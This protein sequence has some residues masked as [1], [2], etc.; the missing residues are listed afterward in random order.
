M[1]DPTIPHFNPGGVKDRVDT[2]DFKWAEIGF[3][4]A[5]FDWDEG[6]DIEAKLGINLPVKDQFGSFSCGGQAW[7]QYAGVLEASATGTLEERSAKFFYA[8]TYQFG[9]GS[10]GRDNADIFINQGS[11][12]ELVLPSY[13]PGGSTTEAFITRGQDITDLARTD[14][15]TAQG[16]SYAQTGTSIDAIA[17]AIRD[18]RGAVLGLDGQNNGTW[19]SAFPKPPTQTE[20]RHWVF[21][22][23]PK[24]INGVK[25]IGFLNSWGDQ[26]GEGGWQWI[27]EQ[28]FTLGHVWSGWTHILAPILP[29]SFHH[30]FVSDLKFEQTGGD[31]IALQKALQLDGSFPATVP[32]TGFYGD[33][34]R[35]AVLAFQLKYMIAPLAE[36]HALQGKTVG[37]KTRAKLNTLFN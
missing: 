15:H 17:Q 26:I 21:A 1:T 34:T 37:P 22:G 13:L 33:I 27:P 9:G 4:S 30:N 6:Y 2:R 24:K 31:I 25:H 12:R 14:A 32:T 28:Y 35:R 10:T 19:A 11:C 20:W 23:K 8:Q 16:F 36:L 5:P 7:G 18:N 3:G 29:P